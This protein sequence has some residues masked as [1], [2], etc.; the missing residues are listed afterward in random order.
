MRLPLLMLAGLLSLLACIPLNSPG[1]TGNNIYVTN[2]AFTP[3]LDSGTANKDDIL[4]VTF[5]WADSAS[6]VGHTI[7]WDDGPTHPP[8]DDLQFSGT[9]DVSLEPGQYSYHCSVHNEGFGMSGVI[10]VLPFGY[11]PPAANRI[12]P[13]ASAVPALVTQPSP[14][15][16]QAN[17]KQA[18]RRSQPATS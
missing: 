8:D 5:R 15:A 13:K 2:F 10:I 18:A 3:V 9:Y 12:N 16:V 6:G 11:Q 7:V 17:P 1:A 4:V 14:A